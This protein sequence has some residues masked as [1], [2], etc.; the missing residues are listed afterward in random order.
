MDSEE[1]KQSKKNF[2]KKKINVI[3]DFTEIQN[4][5]K[6]LLIKNEE[7]IINYLERFIYTSNLSETS[8]KQISEIFETID[9]K[10][11]NE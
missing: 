9:S 8:K 6:K 2:T 7:I 10:I 1:T 11:I 3:N 5:V 4:N